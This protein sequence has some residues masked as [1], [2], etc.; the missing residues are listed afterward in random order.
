MTITGSPEWFYEKGQTKERKEIQQKVEDMRADFLERFSPEKLSEMSGEELLKKIFGN[1]SKAMC[2][3]LTFN[4]EYRWFG[5]AGKYKYLFIVYKNDGAY[6]WKKREGQKA[7]DISYEEAKIKAKE[8]TD[9]LIK[10]TEIIKESAPLSTIGEYIELD[11]KLS[12]VF[13]YTYPWV[14]KY[15]Q[16]VFP[17]FFPGMYAEETINR[18]LKI[19]GLPNHG[20]GKRII[21]AGELSLFI[22]KC[23]LNNIVF[24]DVYAGEWGWEKTCTP[25]QNAASNYENRIKSDPVDTSFYKFTKTK[26]PMVPIVTEDKVESTIYDI[27]EEAEYINE[28]SQIEY[29]DEEQLLKDYTPTPV[30]APKAVLNKSTKTYPRDIEQTKIAIARANHKCEFNDEHWTFTRRSDNLPYTEAHHLIPLSQQHL[31]ENRLDVPANIVSLCSTCHNL[32]HYGKDTERRGILIILFNQRQSELEE[33]GIY[34]DLKA[35][36]RMYNI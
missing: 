29:T 34:V 18:A 5:A 9:K 10:C 15:F 14:I 21:N 31:F 11:R 25:C 24:N 7:I 2:Q 12:S 22:R 16:M 35:L 19:L 1:S 30:K 3:I 33:A 17:Q 32:I 28:L 36:L 13:F 27:N 6:N 8:V 23:K 20:K 4:D 26:K